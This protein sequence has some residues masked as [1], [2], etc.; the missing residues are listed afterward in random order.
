VRC[1]RHIGRR[2]RH[3]TRDEGGRTPRRECPRAPRPIPR[4][5]RR[6]ISR[7]VCAPARSRVSV[8]DCRDHHERSAVNPSRPP[9][10]AKSPR[11]GDFTA[12]L[13]A[14]SAGLSPSSNVG[15]RTAAEAA[16]PS[17]PAA[18]SPTSPPDR[19]CLRHA[20]FQVTVQPNVWRLTD[21]PEMP[22]FAV[23]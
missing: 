5:A 13:I 7:S 11:S 6:A 3:R 18:R 10:G 14:R 22:G 15:G 12:S 4:A 17:S 16:C 20:L 9:W 2:I 21:V 1:L 19:F 23:P 8:V